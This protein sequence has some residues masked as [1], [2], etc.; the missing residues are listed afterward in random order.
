MQASRIPACFGKVESKKM[1]QSRIPACVGSLHNIQTAARRFHGN[2]STIFWPWAARDL[3]GS[4]EP[5]I[6][7]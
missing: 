5:D 2:S 1:R 3:S 7:C 4:F 6:Q